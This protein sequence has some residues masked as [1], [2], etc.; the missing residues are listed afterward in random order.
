LNNNTP[1]RKIL[2]NISQHN[3]GDPSRGSFKNDWQLQFLFGHD[4]E[5]FDKLSHFGRRGDM[6][7][8]RLS[9]PLAALLT[10]KQLL[11]TDRSQALQAL[12]RLFERGRIR[13]CR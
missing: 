12:H 11:A 9:V 3:D 8:D 13:L 5:R 4:R 10:Q 1:P 2:I 6:H 7:V